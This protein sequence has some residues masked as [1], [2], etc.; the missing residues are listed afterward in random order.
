MGGRE[1]LPPS[2]IYQSELVREL[3]PLTHLCWLNLGLDPLP[4]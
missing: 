1:P 4:L 2:Q 3:Q